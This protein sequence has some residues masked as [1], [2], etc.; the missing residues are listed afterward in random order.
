MSIVEQRELLGM[1]GSMPVRLAIGARR[2]G[3]SI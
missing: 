3:A 2:L 1:R